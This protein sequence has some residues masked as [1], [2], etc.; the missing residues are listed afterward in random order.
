MTGKLTIPAT[1]VAIMF[2][3]KLLNPGL[4]DPDF[5]WHL[6]TGEYIMG[7]HALPAADIFSFTR[8][9]EL[10]VLH[11][12]LT[13]VILYGVF[14]FFGATGIRILVAAMFAL[15]FY[16]LMKMAGKLLGDPDRAALIGFIFYIPVLAFAAPRPQLFSFLFFVLFLGILLDFKYFRRTR[17]F[18][19]IPPVMLAWVNLH[20]AFIVGLALLALFLACEWT[21]VLF[22]RERDAENLRG[23]RHLS[24][25]ALAAVLVTAI[26]PQFFEMWL[27]PFQVVSMEASQNMISEWRSPDFHDH[28]YKYFL[29]LVI[30]FFLALVYSRRKPDLTEVVLPLFFVVAGMVSVRHIPLAC[31][32]MLPL[33]ALFYRERSR[34]AAFRRDGRVGKLA[35]MLSDPPRIESRVLPRLNLALLLTVVLAIVAVESKYRLSDPGMASMPIKAAEFVATHGIKGNMFNSYDHGGY[36]IYRLA[37][38]RKVFIDGR[39]DVYGD[40]FI[41]QYRDIYMGADGW[42]EKFDRFRID[43]VICHLDAPIRQLLLADGSFKEVYR[44]ATHAVLLHDSPENQAVLSM[45]DKQGTVTR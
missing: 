16:V 37:P 13:E 41:N 31:C 39:A 15:T 30:G 42:K 19:A 9:G 44:D 34:L 32:V 40:A 33:F 38:E 5:F 45:L 11:E 2:A 28:F 24:L 23:L 35:R 20:G 22:A 27:Y 43:Y 18:M 8:Y 14:Q 29:L 36:L 7:H 3:L 25:V 6:K 21:R 12:W 1:L 10:W 4:Y 17:F 26:N